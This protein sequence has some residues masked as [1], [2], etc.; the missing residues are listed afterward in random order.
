MP[1]NFHQ[2]R[3]FSIY[4]FLLLYIYDLFNYTVNRADDITSDGRM[5]SV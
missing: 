4:F 2:R 1:G 3:S 5:V